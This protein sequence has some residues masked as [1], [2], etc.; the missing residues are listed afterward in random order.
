MAETV[1][2]MLYFKLEVFN[3]LPLGMTIMYSSLDLPHGFQLSVESNLRFLW[4][5]AFCDWLV[6]LAPMRNKIR[7]NRDLLA[8]VFPRLA[9]VH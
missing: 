5:T 8:R 2:I 6:K 4:L 9:P 1:R 7:I 3:S